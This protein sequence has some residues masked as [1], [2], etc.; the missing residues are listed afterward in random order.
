MNTALHT[1]EAASPAPARLPVTPAHPDA[2]VFDTAALPGAGMPNERFARVAARRAFVDL[3]L[4]FLQALV[5]LSDTP[6]G[7]GVDWLRRQVRNAE[8]PVDLWLLR[9]PM[10]AALAGSDPEHRR[11]RQALRRSLDS[12]F[13]DSECGAPASNYAPIN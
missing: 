13:P 7:G 2:T 1:L 6:A 9:A 3:K 8:E 11:Q 5:C 10:F 12:L 4:T